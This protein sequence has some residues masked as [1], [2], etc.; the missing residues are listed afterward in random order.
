MQNLSGSLNKKAEDSA[1]FFVRKAAFLVISSLS[2]LQFRKFRRI[3][4]TS[5]E[6]SG[7]S[8]N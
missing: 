1:D 2:G 5:I 8:K 4:Q 3:P 7:F 6:S